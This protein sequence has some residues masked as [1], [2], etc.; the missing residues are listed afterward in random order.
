MKMLQENSLCSYLKQIKMSFF[1]FYKM[2][3]GQNR[4]CLRGLVKVGGGKRWE[5]GVGR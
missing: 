3:G 2:G 1:F 4:S 5:K